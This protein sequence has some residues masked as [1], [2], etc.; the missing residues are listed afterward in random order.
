MHFQIYMMINFKPMYHTKNTEET[1]A[2]MKIKIINEL[3]TLKK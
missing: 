3:I 1:I 2:N